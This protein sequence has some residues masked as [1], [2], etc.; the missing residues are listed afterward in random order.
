MGTSRNPAAAVRRSVTSNTTSDKAMLKVK[1]QIQQESAATGITT[2]ASSIRMTSGAPKTAGPD[3]LRIAESPVPSIRPPSANPLVRAHPAVVVSFAGRSR[4]WHQASSRFWYSSGTGYSS[5][6]VGMSHAVLVD[7]R[8]AGTRRP[9]VAPRPGYRPTGYR[10]ILQ[11][12]VEI[13]RTRQHR[14][15]RPMV[16][17]LRCRPFGYSPRSGP[18]PWRAPAAPS[19]CSGS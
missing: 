15:P 16:D 3:C 7:R 19:S 17:L 13:D 11:L 10:S 8:A 4:P 14:A 12:G 6:G 9:A 2:I 18:C 1:E 5:G